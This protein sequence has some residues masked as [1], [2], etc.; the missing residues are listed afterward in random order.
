[1]YKWIVIERYNGYQATCEAY[2]TKEEA[3]DKLRKIEEENKHFGIY[4]PNHY[5]VIDIEE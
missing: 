4:E 2:A 3:Q 1:M 5:E